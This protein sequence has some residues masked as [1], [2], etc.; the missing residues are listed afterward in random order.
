MSIELFNIRGIPDINPGDDIAELLLVALAKEGKSLQP[1]DII[2]VAHKI[3]S[4]S[5]NRI[6]LY[7]DVS[8]STEAKHLAKKVRKDPRKVEI[9]LRESRKVIRAVDRTELEEGVLITEHNLGF[10]SANACIDESNIE[11]VEAALL[12]P[13][14]PDASA[15]DLRSELEIKTK[16]KPI[17]VVISDTFGRAWRVGQVNV[18]IGLA[19]VPATNH[20]GGTLD[21][22]GQQLRV[23]QPAYADEL[24]AA[25]GLLMK[26]GAKTPVT[27]FRGLEWKPT[28]S[29]AKELIRPIQEDLFR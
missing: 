15:H 9:I 3:I 4:K 28:K 29:S 5:E 2:V 19:A 20:L 8:P 21:G 13:I 10:I 7:K 12:L 14:D 22:F 27:I 18:A 26:K 16:L 24:A 11:Q 1:G 6:V 17:G 23:T 25:S